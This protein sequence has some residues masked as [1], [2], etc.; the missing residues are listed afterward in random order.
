M[1]FAIMRFVST[2]MK[3]GYHTGHNVPA[4]DTVMKERNRIVSIL[5]KNPMGIG[6]GVLGEKEIEK[7]LKAI[8][9]DSTEELKRGPGDNEN[10]L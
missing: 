10:F 3:C 7:L 1:G 9:D 8:L 2:C 6:G 5:S 4:P